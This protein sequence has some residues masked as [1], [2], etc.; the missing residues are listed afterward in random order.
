MFSSAQKAIKAEQETS[1]PSRGVIEQKS[2]PWE[3]SYKNSSKHISLNALLGGKKPASNTKLLKS[4]AKTIMSKVT[5]SGS[6]IT[7]NYSHLC[8]LPIR[9]QVV[10]CHLSKLTD[11]K[12]IL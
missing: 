11:A 2:C 10:A 3:L 6:I 12:S 8:L 9:Y 1:W 5:D 4:F 7:V